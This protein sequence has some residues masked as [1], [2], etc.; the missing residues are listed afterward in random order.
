MLVVSCHLHLLFTWILRSSICACTAHMRTARQVYFY[1]RTMSFLMKS[2]GLVIMYITDWNKRN[3][4]PN[5]EGWFHKHAN[6]WEFGENN[7]QKAT[8]CHIQ[9]WIPY[10]SMSTVTVTFPLS[11]AYIRIRFL[12]IHKFSQRIEEWIST[13]LLCE[14][15]KSLV[16]YET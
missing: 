9:L 3:R 13:S 15:N 6:A 16:N 11:R 1:F 14:Y 2:E 7:W 5:N 12:G 4:I 8:C 10:L